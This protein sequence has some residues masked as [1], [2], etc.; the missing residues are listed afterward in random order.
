L[1]TIELPNDQRVTAAREFEGV[2]Q[3]RAVGDS[4]RHLFGENLL[5]PGFGQRIALQGQVLIDGRN[6]SIADQQISIGFGVM[7][8]ASDNRARGEPDALTARR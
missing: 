4:T 7:S 2:M 3:S 8:P 6:T 1:Y 5:A